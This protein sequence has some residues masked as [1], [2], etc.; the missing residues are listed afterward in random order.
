MTNVEKCIIGKEVIAEHSEPEMILNENR[1][2][3]KKAGAK[4]TRVKKES[5]S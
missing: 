1:K 4:K 3:L 2:S 5:V